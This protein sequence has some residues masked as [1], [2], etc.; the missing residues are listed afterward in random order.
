[1]RDVT[2]INGVAI[3]DY[4]PQPLCGRKTELTDEEKQ[5]LSEIVQQLRKLAINC[6]FEMATSPIKSF[7]FYDPDKAKE[8]VTHGK[9]IIRNVNEIPP[10]LP[11]P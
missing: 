5:K 4:P 7:E 3:I 10:L 6:N 8:V 2:W 9:Q 1:M 11:P